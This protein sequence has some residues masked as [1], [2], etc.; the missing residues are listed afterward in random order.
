MPPVY[1]DH[2][3][4]APLHPV[5]RAAMM[6]AL[7]AGPAN[8]HA[9]Q[10]APG[11]AAARRLKADRAHLAQAVGCVPAE[12]ILTGGATEANNLAI[13]GLA[14][15]GRDRGR[16]RVLIGATEHACVRESAAW[17]TTLG[18]AVEP[19]P[20]T[21]D[22]VLDLTALAAALDDRA[23]VVAAMAVNNETGVRHPIEA[24]AAI[25]RR[26][27]AALHCDAAQ[28]PGRIP[29]PWS[30]SGPTT[31][32]LSAHKV[33][34]PVGI[35]ALILRRDPPTALSAQMHGGGQ[36][37]GLRAGTV[38][39]ALAAGFAAALK[40][41]VAETGDRAAHARLLEQRLLAGLGR[42]GIPFVHNGA[43]APRTLGIIS[44]TLDQPAEMVMD[45]C[46]DL[47][48]SSGAA[49]R[50]VDDGPSRTLL[51]MGLCAEA[52]DRTV[53]ISLGPD[54]AAADIDHA[55]GALVRALG[56]RT[57]GTAGHPDMTGMHQAPPAQH[58]RQDRLEASASAGAADPGAGVPSIGGPAAP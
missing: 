16:H 4:T 18:F 5:A 56:D 35:G 40:E 3:A 34:G 19:L 38:P 2:A 11:L 22:G 36:E 30:P 26:A 20:V 21:A 49:C 7:D 57:C 27:G 14:L 9:D 37:R 41:A 51:A 24:I 50:T 39:V 55:V 58:R 47:A 29:I 6:A 15:A 1:L 31:L 17:L 10:H 48:L 28:A 54:T 46:P 42:A 33:G 8:P 53:R 44:L 43:G 13:K 23:A 32:S 52:A 25:T 45:A 12:V